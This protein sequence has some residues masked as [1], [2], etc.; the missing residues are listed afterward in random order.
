[1]FTRRRLALTC[2]QIVSR[3]ENVSSGKSKDKLTIFSGH[4]TVIAPVLAALGLYHGDRCAWPSYASRI[5]FE[6]YRLKTKPQTHYFRALYNGVDVTAGIPPCSKSLVVDAKSHSTPELSSDLDHKTI[7]VNG[8]TFC[9]LE[10]LR[11]QIQQLISPHSNFDDA[12]DLTKNSLLH[13]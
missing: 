11:W 12:C 4:D 6:L 13:K 2:R 10:S 7:R 9:P 5:V 8:W 3:L 1:M